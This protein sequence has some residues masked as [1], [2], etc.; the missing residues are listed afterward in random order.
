MT[1]QVLPSYPEDPYDKRYFSRDCKMEES[2]PNQMG[3]SS[4]LPWQL[5]SATRA[6]PARAHLNKSCSQSPFYIPAFHPSLAFFNQ[7]SVFPSGKTWCFLNVKII[8]ASLGTSWEGKVQGAVCQNLLSFRATWSEQ[9]LSFNSTFSSLL[10]FH[11]HKQL[12]KCSWIRC[13]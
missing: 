5:R 7:G 9:A 13:K 8:Q 4:L 1:Y 10:S 3:L 6:L 11:M 12:G 2:S